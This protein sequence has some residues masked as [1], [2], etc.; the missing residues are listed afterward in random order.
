MKTPTTTPTLITISTTPTTMYGQLFLLAY[1]QNTRCFHDRSGLLGLA[2]RAACATELYLSGYLLDD[3][4]QVHSAPTPAPIDPVLNK[5]FGAVVVNDTAPWDWLIAVDQQFMELLV[6]DHLEAQGV[7]HLQQYRRLGIFP[8]TR[9]R[10]V[11]E[12][13]AAALADR[14][15]TTL[16]D[17]EAGRPTDPRLLALS[18][19]AL[20][21]SLA[22]VA[23]APQAIDDLASAVELPPICGMQ[24]AVAAVSD[25]SDTDSGGGWCGGF[26]GGF[27]GGSGSACGSG[28]GSGC[29][30]C[31]GCGG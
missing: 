27:D 31:G 18:Q 17:A 25:Q 22:G 29:G 4:S 2:L 28:C 9:R 13:A 21:G 12:D 7:L 24:D 16:D 3:E 26:G 23:G 5:V 1:D 15:L 19:I 8:A 30:G 6:G 11:D 10:P 14:V 20:L